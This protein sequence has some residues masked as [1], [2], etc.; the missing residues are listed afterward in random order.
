M[1]SKLINLKIEPKQASDLIYSGTGNHLF[2]NPQE[3]L[4][5]ERSRYLHI[6]KDNVYEWLIETVGFDFYTYRLL[7]RPYIGYINSV[8]Q[9]EE[10]ST[11][12][13]QEWD[14]LNP[15]I[16]EDKR[17][18]TLLHAGGSTYQF[19]FKEE[20]HAVAFKLRWF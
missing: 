14:K 11:L 20:Q 17:N 4:I 8:K 15:P 7:D 18:W 2:F 13:Y 9:F 1:V 16:P 12:S 19:I 6:P 3:R 10:W 5:M